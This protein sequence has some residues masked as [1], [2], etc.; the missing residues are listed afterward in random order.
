[1]QPLQMD[2]GEYRGSYKLVG[3]RPSLDL[4]NTISW[5]GTDRE[6]DWLES[7]ENLTVWFEAVGLGRVPSG[8]DVIRGAQEI[9]EV[10]ADALVPIA[11]SSRPT[12]E[13]VERFNDR[14]AA[15]LGRRRIDPVELSWTWEPPSQVKEALDPVVL[16]AAD[17]LTGSRHDRI[18]HCPTCRWLFDDQTRNGRRKW[19][20]MA[21][22]GSRAKAR[23]YYQRQ[24][25]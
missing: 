9:R 15:A 21:D 1:M 2:P 10:L 17:L 13:A 23:A 25:S 22:C 3:G 19:C 5:P 7:P 12:T 16:D 18:K 20:D 8:Q 4:I 6:H 14:L 11:Q 24:I